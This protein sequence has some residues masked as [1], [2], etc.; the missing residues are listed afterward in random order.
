MRDERLIGKVIDVVSL[1]STAVKVHPD[2]TGALK[3]EVQAI[4]RTEECCLLR[5]LLVK[6]NREPT[7][8]R[9]ECGRR[10]RRAVAAEGIG[11]IEHTAVLLMDKAYSDNKTQQAQ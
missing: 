4:G 5:H 3:K 10:G 6:S 8:F 9:G 2:G 1:D 7:T 11:S